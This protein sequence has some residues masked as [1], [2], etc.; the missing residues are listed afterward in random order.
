ML[1]NRAMLCMTYLLNFVGLILRWMRTRALDDCKNTVMPRRS[2]RN[3]DRTGQ[4]GAATRWPC[5]VYNREYGKE[6]D[7]W[8]TGIIAYPLSAGQAS[9]GAR[10]M[11]QIPTH[12][13][14]FCLST[15]F[16][17]DSVEVHLRWLFFA[18]LEILDNTPVR[19]HTGLRQQSWISRNDGK[20]P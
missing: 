3:T 6:C 8:S 10:R 20:I 7:F 15:C 18:L 4:C 14:A 16:E 9:S 5:E 19:V 11:H 12:S 1:E 13:G 17:Y 2:S